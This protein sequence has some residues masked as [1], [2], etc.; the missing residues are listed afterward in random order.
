MELWLLVGAVVLIA[1]TVWIVWPAPRGGLVPNASQEGAAMQE[2]VPPQGDR[3]E[4]QYTSATADL[5]AGGVATSRQN[6]TPLTDTAMQSEPWQAPGTAR[7]GTTDPVAA[8]RMLPAPSRGLSLT[9]P[10]TIG[11]GGGMIVAVVGGAGGAWLYSRWQRERNKPINR[12]RRGAEDVRQRL[13]DTDIPEG[14]APMGGA[15]ALLISSLVLAR[16]LRRDTTN[17]PS[18]DDARDILSEALG[19]ARQRAQGV[20]WTDLLELGREQAERVPWS[21]AM[22]RG[23]GQARDL[24]KHARKTREA[25]R[26]RAREVMQTRKTQ[27]RDALEALQEQYGDFEPRKAGGIGI[28]VLAGISAVGYLVWRML[29]GGG[30]H[31]TYTS[32]YM[33]ERVSE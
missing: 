13:S 8:G 4:D 3:F 7:A 2:A 1:L 26:A 31:A 6:S 29:R 18:R 16:A 23:R 27:A 30:G 11:L 5:S 20:S 10:R 12:L 17:M 21:E 22:E 14:A 24:A 15:A 33:A 28:G 32:P 19:L 9:E 25:R